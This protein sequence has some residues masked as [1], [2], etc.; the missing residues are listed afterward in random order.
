[1]DIRQLKYFL[2][3]AEEG[4]ITKAAQR[5]HITQPPLS[6][7]IK[8]LEEELGLQLLERGN[9][10]I[11]L[12]EAG[13]VLRNRAEQMLELMELTKSE[14]QEI[15]DGM[16]GTLTIG[17][18]PATGSLLLEKIHSFNQLYPNINFQLRHRETHSILELVNAGVIE[19]GIVRLPVDSTIYDFIELPEQRIG[20][21]GKPSWFSKEQN[22]IIQ[23]KELNGKPLMMHRRDESIIRDCCIKAGFNPHVFCTSDDIMPLL[24]WA[25]S[26][27]A[28]SLVPDSAK[29]LLPNATLVF[30]EISDPAIK[31][32]SALIWHKRRIISVVAEH[33]ISMFE[34]KN[35][36]L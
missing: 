20:V 16:T 27:I 26:G 10:N 1:M 36:A 34:Q 17:T 30:K 29:N 12:T 14:L 13:H 9:R 2:A 35:V 31:V 4:Q 25:G 7:Q 32:N 23:L 11:R 19:M 5:L 3:V 15:T 24:Y 33:F 8:L 21:A 18:V 6:Q 28:I 22:Q